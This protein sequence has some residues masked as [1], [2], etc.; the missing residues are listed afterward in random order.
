[1]ESILIA[2]IICSGFAKLVATFPFNLSIINQS[3]DTRVGNGF[4]F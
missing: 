2:G 3:D 1:M 4:N